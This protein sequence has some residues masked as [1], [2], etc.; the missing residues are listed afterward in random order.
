MDIT[1]KNI[2]NEIAKTPVKKFNDINAIN[3]NTE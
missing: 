3:P 2:Q 1:N